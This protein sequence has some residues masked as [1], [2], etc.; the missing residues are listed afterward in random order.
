MT[1]TDQDHLLAA[2]YFENAALLHDK[3]GKD[4]AGKLFDFAIGILTKGLGGGH[5][6]AARARSEL[7]SFYHRKGN[8]SEAEKLFNQ[9]LEVLKALPDSPD[10]AQTLFGLAR[11]YTGRG[12]YADAEPLFIQ[13]LE[14]QTTAIPNH[15]KTIDTLRAYADLL[16]KTNRDGD[17]SQMEERANKLRDK[18]EN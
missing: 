14:I 13:A 2:Y 4:D 9:A 18:L 6:E 7:A 12:Q 8:P 15:R 10:L 16:R 17:A 5:P 11:I 3:Q 1:V